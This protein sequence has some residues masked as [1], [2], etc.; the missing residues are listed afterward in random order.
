MMKS[1]LE[2]FNPTNK[3]KVTCLKE[4]VKRIYGISISENYQQLLDVYSN[5]NDLKSRMICDIAKLMGNK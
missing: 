3:E 2:S 4:H 5:R 1:I